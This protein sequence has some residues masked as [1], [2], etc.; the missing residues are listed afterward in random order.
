MTG[1]NNGNRVDYL[2]KQVRAM[3]R[4]IENNNNAKIAERLNKGIETTLDGFRRNINDI[5]PLP[6][7]P[8]AIANKVHD[9]KV[10]DLNLFIEDQR[11]FSSAA[12]YQQAVKTLTVILIS[13]VQVR[14]DVFVLLLVTF[15]FEDSNAIHLVDLDSTTRFIHMTIIQPKITNS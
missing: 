4:E 14:I 11:E 15:M 1:R 6:D 13:H 9:I 5:S 12:P 10:N 3:Y 7:G 2:Q 8:S